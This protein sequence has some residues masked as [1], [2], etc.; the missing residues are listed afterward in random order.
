MKQKVLYNLFVINNLYIDID[1]I[2]LVKQK[3]FDIS[4][5][6]ALPPPIDIIKQIHIYKEFNY[7]NITFQYINFQPSDFPGYMH[8]YGKL[9]NNGYIYYKNIWISHYAI[10]GYDTI[11]NGPYE[12]FICY[13]Q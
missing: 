10:I 11:E 3:L 5:D 13:K 12:T 2:N 6:V 8:Y 1:C 9:D 7:N 4:I